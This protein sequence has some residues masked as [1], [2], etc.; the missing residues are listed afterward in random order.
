[1]AA[2]R[3]CDVVF[4][5]GDHRWRGAMQDI[6]H[7]SAVAAPGAALVV[8]DIAV[9]PGRALSATTR[10]N[11]TRVDELYGPNVSSGEPSREVC[12]VLC[13]SAACLLWRG[14]THV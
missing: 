9:G 10:R 4:V 6:E 13:E 11:L 14:A 3:V 8:D 7:T 2:A 5:D 1:M 12:E